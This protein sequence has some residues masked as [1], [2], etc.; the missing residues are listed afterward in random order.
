LIM[1]L[2]FPTTPPIYPKSIP[3]SSFP[4]TTPK[5]SPLVAAETR[6][7]RAQYKSRTPCTPVP[8][9]RTS[10]PSK[11]TAAST[12]PSSLPSARLS[13]TPD[14]Q[15]HRQRPQTLPRCTSSAE[16]PQKAFLRERFMARCLERVRKDRER[17]IH[18]RR[19]SR[20]IDGPSDGSSDGPDD[21]YMDCE[22]MDAD[23][24]ETD[25]T[26]MQDE[27]CFI[28]LIGCLVVSHPFTHSYPSSS[29]AL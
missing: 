6:R 23:E 25:E 16:S 27:V 17:A 24:D 4:P 18:A 10:L 9:R 13:F 2:Q 8:N 3:Y 12:N 19:R 22:D 20:S 5:S 7:R 26:V 21:A 11:F 1:S 28:C 15:P 14:A 29:A